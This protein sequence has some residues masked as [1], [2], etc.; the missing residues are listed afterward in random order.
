M[1]AFVSDITGSQRLGV[2]PLVFLFALG[3]FL[4]LWVKPDG[5][6]HR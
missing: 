2:T 6:Q 4:L 5:E 1:I 3:L